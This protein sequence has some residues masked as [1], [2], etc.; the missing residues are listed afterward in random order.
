MVL[1]AAGIGVPQNRLLAELVPED[2]AFL[3]ASARIERPVQ[4]QV[5]SS[6]SEPSAELW[7]PQTGVIALTVTDNDGRTVQTGMVGP[8]GCIGLQNLFEHMP[9]MA[10][11]L[12]QIGGTMAVIPS[13]A[14]HAAV[15]VRP[16]VQ[17][18]FS[19][20]LFA[21]SAEC[22][23]TVACNRL[24]SLEARCCRWLLMVQDRTGETDL[25]LTQENLATMLGSGRPRINALLASLERARLVQRFR[26]R[27]RILS[28]AGLKRRSC[29]CYRLLAGT[30]ASGSTI[31]PPNVA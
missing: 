25:P 23:Q 10:D 29:E 6:R 18:A 21:L 31:F 15:E 14:V 1:P 2:R 22:L 24:H 5:L 17:A 7:F 28:R 8:E 12:V 3:L 30:G 20:F 9:P 4:G 11:A 16:Q 13:A 26:G 19:R 27:I